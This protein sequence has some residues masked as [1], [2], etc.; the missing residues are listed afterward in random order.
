MKIGDIVAC[1]GCDKY[2]CIGRINHLYINGDWGLVVLKQK[3]TANYE[4]ELND[5]TTCYS[6]QNFLKVLSTIEEL[7]TI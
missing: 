6:Q 1:N 7:L 3:I 2:E 4:L 5:R